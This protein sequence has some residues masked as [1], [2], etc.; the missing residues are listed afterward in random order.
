[1]LDEDVERL[2]RRQDVARVGSLASR[3]VDERGELAQIDGASDLELK[4]VSEAGEEN[5]SPRL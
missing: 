3:L 1:M 2:R 5:G 4:I